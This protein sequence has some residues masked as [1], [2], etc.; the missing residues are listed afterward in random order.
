MLDRNG[1]KHDVLS[2][3]EAAALHDIRRRIAGVSA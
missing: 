3:Q 2:A 1:T